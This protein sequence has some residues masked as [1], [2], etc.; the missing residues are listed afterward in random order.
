MRLSRIPGVPRVPRTR[1]ARVSA[2]A[3]AT[4]TVAALTAVLVTGSGFDGEGAHEGSGRSDSGSADDAERTAMALTRFRTAGA[5]GPSEV[6]VRLPSA[7]AGTV[8]VRAVADHRLHRAVGMYEVTRDG[9]SMRGLLAWDL[10]TIAVPGS[11]KTAPDTGGPEAR[12]AAPGPVTTAVQAA[13]RAATLNSDR[14]R[15]RPYGTAPLDRALH[16]ALS[17]AADRP[18][19]SRL[20]VESRRLLP[21]GPRAEGSAVGPESSAPAPAYSLDAAGDLRRVTA[22]VA[23]GRQA[24]VDFATTRARTGVPGAPW[25]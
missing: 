8:T 9:H 4:A 13:R 14:W 19:G 5:G 6:T 25:G 23:P 22:D 7:E 15:H 21:R 1:K 2:A 12:P 11:S 17:V 3:A 18:A 24:T 10:E 20:P 16:L